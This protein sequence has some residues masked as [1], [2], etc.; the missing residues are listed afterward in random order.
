MHKRKRTENWTANDKR[1]LRELC[2]ERLNI[3]EN[4]CVDTEN[5]RLKRECWAEIN[6]AFNE[7]S[8]TK[9]DV[10]RIQFQWRNM[11]MKAKTAQST[12]QKALKK[13]CDDPPP[14][15]PSKDDRELIELVSTEYK[16]DTNVLDT[17]GVAMQ[18]QIKDENVSVDTLDELP[19]E[20]KDTE[21]NNYSHSREN[22]S[23]NLSYLQSSTKRIQ[24]KKK[25][26]HD[27]ETSQKRE[28][29]ELTKAHMIE[30]HAERMAVLDMEKQCRQKELENLKLQME[31]LR[32]NI[33]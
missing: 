3:I 31:L 11:K 22:M 17:Y 23:A 4:K 1:L 28:L 26:F 10:A 7:L 8:E 20:Y 19:D 18:M 12:Y 2:A 25:I 5:N 9:R 15:S 29:F 13:S 14:Q 6:D 30:E 16:I 32:K 27:P 33:G 21:E 24:R